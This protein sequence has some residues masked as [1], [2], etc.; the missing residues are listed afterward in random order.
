MSWKDIVRTVAP[1][2]ATAFGTP[3]AGL[4]TKFLADKLLGKPDANETEIE[5]FMLGAS[6]EDMVKL[7]QLDQDFKVQMRRL[8]IDVYELDVKDR[9]S[10]RNL[11]KVNIWPQIVLSAIF[12]AGYFGV[13][14]FLLSS[15]SSNIMVTDEFMKG[16]FTTVIGV[17][18][19]AMPQILNFWFGSSLGSK[20][21]TAK[22]KG[23]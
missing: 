13:L 12:V 18:T 15:G 22:S 5:Q 8:D 4:A 16:V 6:S 9:D 17:M 21:K 11:Y 2:I 1:T 20:E 7:K 3:A 23:G 19:A 10:A 14:Y